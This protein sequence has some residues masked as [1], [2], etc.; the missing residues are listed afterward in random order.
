VTIKRY[1]WIRGRDIQEQEMKRYQLCYVDEDES[2]L[3]ED[4]AEAPVLVLRASQEETRKKAKISKAA[5]GKGN[6]DS[7]SNTNVRSDDSLF[8]YPGVLEFDTEE[9]SFL[10]LTEAHTYDLSSF[11]AQVVPND[12]P[13]AFNRAGV[14]DYEH[15]QHRLRVIT[16]CYGPRYVSDYLMAGNGIFIERHDF[17]QS[18]TPMLPTCGGA[19]LLGRLVDIDDDDDVEKEEEEKEKEKEAGGLP[20]RQ[21]QALQLIAVRVPF[22]YTLLVEPQSIHGDSLMTGMFLMSMTGNHVAMATA[23]TVFMKHKESSKNL[24]ISFTDREKEDLNEDGSFRFQVSD[25]PRHLRPVVTSSQVPLQEVKEIDRQLK[26]EITDTVRSSS[27]FG[28]VKSLV[29]QPVIA[30]SSRWEKT[31]GL[32]LP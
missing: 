24:A 17:I 4:Q 16:Y 21:K 18:I 5:K 32:S 26:E 12:Q 7:S 2:F 20:P 14:D 13:F 29:W 22:G 30:T 27:I 8:E 25:M 1:N 10:P 15:A 23:D 6:E 9:L 11:H 19:V 3:Q 31:L 28:A